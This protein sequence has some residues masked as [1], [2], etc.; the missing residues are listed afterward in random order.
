LYGDGV[1]VVR[2]PEFAGRPE[3]YR[4]RYGFHFHDDVIFT[5]DGEKWRSM[6]QL[7]SQLLRRSMNWMSASE[8]TYVVSDGR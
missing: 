8:M 3:F 7:S 2:D 6:K 5:T 4:V 1:L